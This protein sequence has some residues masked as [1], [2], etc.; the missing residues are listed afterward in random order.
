[1]EYDIESILEMYEDDY[2]PSSMVPG[3]RNMYSDSM[4]PGFFKG[5]SV[6][7]SHGQKLIELTEAGE[8]SVSIAKKLGLKQQTVSNALNA[9]D[10]GIAGNEYKLSKPLK[11]FFKPKNQFTGKELTKNK[12]LIANITEDAPFMSQKE[13]IEKYKINKKTLTKIRDQN[14]LTFRQSYKPTGTQKKEIPYADRYTAQEKSDMYKKRK[15]T[16]TEEDRIKA[17]ERKKKY[18]DKV[19][20]AKKMEP[21]AREFKDDLWKDI[22]RSSDEGDRIK[23][24]EGPKYKSGTTYDKFKNR[25]FLDTLTNTEFG[26]DDLEKYLD[27]GKLKNVTYESVSEPYKLKWDINDSGFREEIQKAYFG[28]KYEPPKKFRSQNTF[29]VHHIGGVA[30]DPFSVQLTFYDENMGLV[31]NKK[32]NENWAKLIER[33]A[34]LSERKEY[35]KFVKSKIGPNIAQTLEFP[36]VGK[37]RTF[38]EMGTD[39]KKLL[40]NEKFKAIGTKQILSKLEKIGCGKAAGGRILMSNGGATLTKCALEGQKKIDRIIAT[41][42]GTKEE[43][44]LAKKLLKFG[45]ESVSLRGLFGPQAAALFALTEAGFTGYDVAKGKP[46]KEAIG[47]NLNYLLG[48]KWKQDVDELEYKRLEGSGVDINQ[49]K[50]L[51]NSY[52]DFEK[53]GE[54]YNTQYLLEQNKGNPQGKPGMGPRDPQKSR[55]QRLQEVNSQINDMYMAKGPQ[56]KSTLL[57]AAEI[58]NDPS[59]LASSKDA[60]DILAAQEADRSI[61]P[62]AQSEYADERKRLEREKERLALQST[63]KEVEQ[64]F[65][66]SPDGIQTF[67]DLNKFMSTIPE[68]ADQSYGITKV[69]PQTG[70]YNV[71]NAY[72]EARKYIDSFKPEFGYHGSQQGA[73]RNIKY[74]EGGITELRSKYE[75]KK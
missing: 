62:E 9:I 16:E 48:P 44:S 52:K 12:E 29:H 14:N 65:G 7:K 75:Y 21:S 46:L 58:Q 37:T 50:L 23:L 15:A 11:N 54:L 68:Y 33:N 70:Q 67:S 34:P 41:G 10:S 27:S 64:A 35:L 19:Y 42:K 57:R 55:A 22:A 28:D 31:H 71:K 39:I 47:K 40:S 59:I 20:A 66:F 49:L 1:M 26:Y 2:N 72:D 5:E 6:V 56:Q 74:S 24:I 30:A 32:F 18:E 4:R 61:L 8:S 43:L 51:K 25:R 38:G 69:G 17:R 3:P 45:K 36:E 60:I 73:N 53:I 63:D 13:L